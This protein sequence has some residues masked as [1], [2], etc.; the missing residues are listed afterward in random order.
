ML[1]RSLLATLLVC[2]GFAV[3]GCGNVAPYQR[4][5]L[6]HPTMQPESNQSPGREHMQAVQEG[7]AG[8]TESHASGCG[9]N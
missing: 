7:A 1:T 4:A 2:L 5:R 3:Q 8:G 6:A 9:C